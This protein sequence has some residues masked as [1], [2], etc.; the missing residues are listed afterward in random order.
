V[1]VG[2]VGHCT[3]GNGED[4]WTASAAFTGNPSLKLMSCRMSNR[5]I[6]YENII[7]VAGTVLPGRYSNCKYA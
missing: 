1:G 2:Y 5:Q 6:E 7:N 4:T 3:T